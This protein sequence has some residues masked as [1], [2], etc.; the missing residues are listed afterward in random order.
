MIGSVEETTE[1][2]LEIISTTSPTNNDIVLILSHLLFSIGASL[3]KCE[4]SLSKDILLRYASNP[5]LGNVLMAQAMFIKETWKGKTDD[6]E[7]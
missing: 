2:L 5:T 6:R 4:V 3:E 7:H 1:K